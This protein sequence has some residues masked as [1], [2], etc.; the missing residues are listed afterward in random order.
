MAATQYDVARLAGVS[1]RTV[2]RC[3]IEPAAVRPETL[4]RVMELARQ[5]GY[6]PNG[7]AR[8]IRYGRSECVALLREGVHAHVPSPLVWGVHQR[9]QE[10][11]LQLMLGELPSDSPDPQAFD[12]IMADGLLIP[13]PR[14][15]S[16]AMESYVKG[17]S[18][19][20][21]WINTLGPMDCVCPDDVRAGREATEHL[22]ALGHRRI[23][24]L[25][26]LR[27]TPPGDGQYCN[28]RERAA[29]YAQAMAA[30]GL[31]PRYVR[32][33]AGDSMEVALAFCRSVLPEPGRPT[34]VVVGGKQDAQALVYTAYA[35]YGLT[36]P[37]DLSIITFSDR[38]LWTFPRISAFVVPWHAM[39]MLATDLLVHR[40]RECEAGPMV[41]RLRMEWYAGA[42]LAP[43]CGPAPRGHQ[44]TAGWTRES[45]LMYP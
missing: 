32:P 26:P 33:D 5:I 39:G 9:L 17:V 16:E 4:S 23:A 42:T 13:C 22:M 10:Y 38:R 24:F 30:A 12:A 44:A 3:F 15:R 43:P 8:R 37:R 45:S 20:A 25:G 7:A 34:A 35:S 41:R 2:S 31:E 1:Q 14:G 19:P 11:H 28:G 40:I 36:I 29:G 21:V 27:E 6:R 18:L